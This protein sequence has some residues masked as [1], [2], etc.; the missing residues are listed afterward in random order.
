[1][2]NRKSFRGHQIVLNMILLVVVAALL[3]FIVVLVRNKLLQNAQSLGNAL[4]HSYA[5]E[6]EMSINS[7]EREVEL[8]SQYVDELSGDGGGFDAIQSWLSGHFSKLIQ[9]LGPGMVDLYA[10]V[11]GQIVAANPWE[12]DKTYQYQDTDWYRQA[13]EAGGDVVCGEVYDD[14]VTGQR[15]F[16]I[17]KAL[18][19]RGDVFAMDVYIQNPAFH[20]TAQTLPE[21]CSYYLCDS[22]GTLLYSVTKWEASPQALQS[23]ADYLLAPSVAAVYS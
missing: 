20:N 3:V 19:D 5:V 2:K 7:L 15:I 8:V 12:G 10:V 6:E 21:D 13:V 1:M 14:A 17:S 22:G 4:V 16:T 11:D 9:T 23:Y 18:N